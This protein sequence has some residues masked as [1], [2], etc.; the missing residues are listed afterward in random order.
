MCGLWYISESRNVYISR[1]WLILQSA[2]HK[3]TVRLI[4][5]QELWRDQRTVRGLSAGLSHSESEKTEAESRCVSRVMCVRKNPKDFIQF[6][7]NCRKISQLFWAR[8]PRMN[9][10]QCCPAICNKV[11]ADK[12]T[13][14]KRA[15]FRINCSTTVS[16][17]KTFSGRLWSF[18][19]CDCQLIRKQTQASLTKYICYLGVEL[20]NKGY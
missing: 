13:A 5:C 6:V 19:S 10:Y 15:G 4:Q 18:I 7:A 9:R 11:T 2:H 17:K 14:I 3:L 20:N 8:M 16:K 1:R 12:N